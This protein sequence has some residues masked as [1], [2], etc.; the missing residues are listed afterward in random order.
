MSVKPETI[1]MSS[2]RLARIEDTPADHP[3]YATFALARSLNIRAK[4]SR[5]AVQKASA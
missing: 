5:G 2:K 3:P 1:G 4:R